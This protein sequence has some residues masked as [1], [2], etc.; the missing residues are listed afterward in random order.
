MQ[1]DVYALGC[2]LYE[3]VTGQMLFS[4]ATSTPA[5]MRAHFQPRKLP[6]SWP[7]GVPPG[8]REVLETALALDPTPRY[9]QAG[10]LATAVAT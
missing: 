7:E 2:I 10:D 4:P 1:T 9:R 3:V 5:V 8:L 6:E